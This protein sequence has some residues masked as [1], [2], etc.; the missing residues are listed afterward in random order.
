MEAF[1][2]LNEN[3][4]IAD[5]YAKILIYIVLLLI[6]HLFFRGIV[7]NGIIHILSLLIILIFSYE[8]SQRDFSVGTDTEN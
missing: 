3:V 6:S 2:V 1:D 4:F 5:T 7:R 8:F